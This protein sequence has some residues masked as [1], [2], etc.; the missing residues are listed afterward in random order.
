MGHVGEEPAPGGT[1]SQGPHLVLLL[2]QSWQT[3]LD[4]RD[5]EGEVHETPGGAGEGGGH[6]GAQEGRHEDGAN[7]ERSDGVEE[8]LSEMNDLSSGLSLCPPLSPVRLSL[9]GGKEWLVCAVVVVALA[10]GVLGVVVVVEVVVLHGH[11]LGGGGHD[12]GGSIRQS[13]SWWEDR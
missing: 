1:S 6:H 10:V 8:V 3:D 5:L 11:W 4:V 9:L 13:K 12:V 2:I 7:S